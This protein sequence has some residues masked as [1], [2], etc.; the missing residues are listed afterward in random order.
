MPVRTPKKA[1]ER[2]NY[3]YEELLGHIRQYIDDNFGG[4]SVFLNSDE[5]KECGFK[6]T[7]NER[8][9]M[10]TYLSLPVEG[11]RA[12]VRSFP[13]LK[14]LFSCLL[15]IELES[16]IK[17]VREQTLTSDKLIEFEK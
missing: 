6:D 13:V 10:F 8:A 14:V 7:P 3:S 1:E 17:V 4:V 5:Y 2:H 9:K 11:E 16:K 12:R 15:G